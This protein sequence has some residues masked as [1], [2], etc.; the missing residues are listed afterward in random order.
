MTIKRV[1]EQIFNIIQR[2]LVK[3]KWKN[4]AMSALN[5]NELLFEQKSLYKPPLEELQNVLQSILTR[6]FENVTVNVSQ[7]PNLSAS[8]YGLMDIGL[9]GCP[10]LLELGGAPYLLPKVQK[11]KL[12]DIKAIC[13]KSMGE[14]KILAVGAGA[15]PYPLRNTNCEGIFNLSISAQ[16]EIKNGSYTAKITGLQEDCLLEPIPDTETRCALLLNLYVCRGEPGPVLK[17]NC[18]KRTGHMNFIEC[19]RKGLYEKYQDKCVGLGGLFLLKN[20][21]AHQHVMRDFSRSPIHTESELNQW[22]KFFEMP[23]TLH[24]VG[25]LVTHEHDLDLRLQHFHS[26]SRTKWGG[27]YHYDTT[28][29]TIEYE[30]YFNVAERIVRVDKPKTT[31]KFGRD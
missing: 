16:D 7:C 18:K 30:A 14:G 1:V 6:N 10:T 2:I 4:S 5:A 15:G 12:Y 27:H 25:T 28:P 9:G 11:D 17:I 29:D 21:K 24:A 19:I 20:G 3:T 8:E 13:R 23:G 31:H 26:F 22:L